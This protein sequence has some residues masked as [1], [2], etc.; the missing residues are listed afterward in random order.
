MLW[1]SNLVVGK[2]RDVSNCF[3]CIQGILT[4]GILK[5]DPM[6]SS[7]LNQLCIWITF[8]PG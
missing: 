8:V 6:A 2:Y 4:N 1:E 5:F 7:G 3:A